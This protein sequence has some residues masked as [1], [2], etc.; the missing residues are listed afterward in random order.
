MVSCKQIGGCQEM[1]V[2]SWYVCTGLLLSYH[3][4]TMLLELD[5]IVLDMEEEGASHLADL[6][7]F[8]I[9]N[10]VCVSVDDNMFNVPG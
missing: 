2:L 1:I 3:A 9:V 5:A 8:T 6:N 10:L 7:K 4:E